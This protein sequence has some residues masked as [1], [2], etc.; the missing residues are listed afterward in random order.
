MPRAASARSSVASAPGAQRVEAA[1]RLVEQQQRRVAHE[2]ASEREAAAA[3]RPTA[4]RRGGAAAARHVGQAGASERIGDRAVAIGPRWRELADHVA[5]AVRGAQPRHRVL[6]DERDARASQAAAAR[7]GPARTGRCRRSS[8][9][10]AARR[11]PGPTC[12]MSACSSV[13]LPPPEDPTSATT[14]PRSTTSAA[15]SSTA[16]V[17]GADRETLDVR[18]DR[19]ACAGRRVL[20]SQASPTAMP[21]SAIAAHGASAPQGL[22]SRPGTFSRTMTAQSAC[23]GCGSDAEERR[24]GDEVDRLHEAQPERR[25]H[26]AAQRRRQLPGDDPPG[27]L[28]RRHGMLD[29][30]GGQGG[31][32]GRRHDPCDRWHRE[33]RQQRDQRQRARVGR[34]RRRRRISTSSARTTSSTSDV[35]SSARPIHGRAT[36]APRPTSTPT[37]VPAIAASAAIRISSSPPCRKRLST[38]RPSSSVP[39]GAAA[40]AVA[41]GAPTTSSSAC[42]ASQRRQQRDHAGRSARASAPEPAQALQ[43]HVARGRRSR[44]RSATANASATI[45]AITTTTLD[46]SATSRAWMPCVRTLPT[47]G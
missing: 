26:G 32:R 2:R 42:G 34:A 28:A 45:A 6:P 33:D 10:P 27:R 25:Q 13:V 9:V 4:R 16:F 40:L 37:A 12:P 35:R 43:I 24:A 23:G 19:H 1:G 8:R 5:H 3:A 39:S 41:N 22:S 7:R 31:A 15:S 29:I 36:A 38:S 30:A 17:A 21:V 44:T 20:R 47:P 14:D 11:S 46:T 18:D